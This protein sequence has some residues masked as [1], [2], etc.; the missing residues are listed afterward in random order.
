MNFSKKAEYGLRAVVFLAKN[1]PATKSVREIS[2]TENISAKYLEQLFVK[3]KKEKIVMS[4]KGKDGG[5]IL[6]KKPD[7][8]RVGRI[9]EALEGPIKIMNCADKKCNSRKCQSKKV[10]LLLEKQIKQTL[11]KIK[12]SE[13]I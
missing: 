11:N 13:L 8:I 7:L 9:I 6:C 3:L 4:R 10:W 12:L 5:Y 2:L 1:Y